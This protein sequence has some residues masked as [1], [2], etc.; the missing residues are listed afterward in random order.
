MFDLIPAEQRP[1]LVL[2]RNA[3]IVL[4][5]VANVGA[6]FFHARLAYGKAP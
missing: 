3:F 4:A 5:L 2:K 1:E 6:D